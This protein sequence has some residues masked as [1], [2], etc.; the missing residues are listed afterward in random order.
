MMCYC[1]CPDVKCCLAMWSVFVGW[2]DVWYFMVYIQL[3]IF[4]LGFFHLSPGVILFQIQKNHQDF[5]MR[6]PTFTLHSLKHRKSDPN[7]RYLPHFLG[8]NNPTNALI[9]PEL[10]F[11]LNHFFKCSFTFLWTGTSWIW[12]F[13]VQLLIFNSTPS[14]TP[15]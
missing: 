5:G 2:T 13:R 15:L 4:V 6:I 14:K 1:S 8:C 12:L 7:F 10:S 11:L 9:K 3:H